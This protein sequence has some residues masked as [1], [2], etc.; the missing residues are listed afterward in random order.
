MKATGFKTGAITF[1]WAV[2]TMD[3]QLSTERANRT[4]PFRASDGTYSL[5]RMAALVLINL[6][7]IRHLTPYAD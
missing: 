1:T 6:K 3:R 4:T 5:V 2:G 7:M